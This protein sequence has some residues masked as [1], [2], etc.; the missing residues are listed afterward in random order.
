MTKGGMVPVPAERGQDGGVV[1]EAVHPDQLVGEQLH[2]LGQGL[3]DKALG[4]GLTAQ[5]RRPL[6]VP[7]QA[8]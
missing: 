2:L 7:C 5:H 8:A 6:Q 3:V 4:E 1:E